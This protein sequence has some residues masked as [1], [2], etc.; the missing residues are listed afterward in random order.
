M[1][2]LHRKMKSCTKGFALWFQSHKYFT[3]SIIFQLFLCHLTAI[4]LSNILLG[5]S[6]SYLWQMISVFLFHHGKK[7]WKSIQTSLKTFPFVTHL[8]LLLEVHLANVR[9]FFA[10]MPSSPPL[11]T[12]MGTI[13]HPN[14]HFCTDLVPFSTFRD[15][16]GFLLHLFNPEGQP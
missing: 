16:S 5:E 7:W 3:Q 8:P 9:F 12:Q 13:F 10:Q 11:Y 1:Q 14:Y 4:Y 15:R 6:F 2:R